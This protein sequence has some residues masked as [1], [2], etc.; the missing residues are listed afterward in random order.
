MNLSKFNTQLRNTVDTGK[1][2]LGI[3]ETIKE[4]LVGEPKLIVVSSSIKDIKKKQLEYYAKL[5]NI[6]MVFYPENGYELGSVCGKPFSV[7][8][9]AIID[10][11]QA[12]IMDVIDSKEEVIKENS[13][14]KIKA[15]KKAKKEEKKIEKEKVKKLKEIRKKEE[16]EKPIQEDEMFKKLVKI[17][18]K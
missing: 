17:K 12:S 14:V 18:K 11:G 15:E 1:I 5:L 13:K 2:V 4:C 7:S 3:N 10:F 9:L 6:K 8:V 16:D